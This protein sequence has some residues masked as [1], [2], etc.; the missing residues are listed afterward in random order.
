MTHTNRATAHE[1]GNHP[2]A[3]GRGRAN[4]PLVVESA[5]ALDEEP[6]HALVAVLVQ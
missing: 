1:R 6:Q 4:G 5:Q 2:D 3:F